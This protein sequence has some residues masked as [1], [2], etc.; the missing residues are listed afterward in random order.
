MHLKI[1]IE[2]TKILIQ[3]E[4]KKIVNFFHYMELQILEKINLKFCNL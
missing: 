3:F 1:D 2:F 4:P